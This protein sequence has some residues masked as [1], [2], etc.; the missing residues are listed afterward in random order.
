MSHIQ[1]PERLTL[2][3]ATTI[4]IG[5]MIG[6]G[7]FL[8]VSSMTKVLPSPA[9]LLAAWLL[10]GILT[11]CGSLTLAEMAARFPHT[12]G[13]YVYMKE[14]Y[15]KLAGY[16]FGWSLL[17]VM[18]TGS[19]AAMAAGAAQ[20]LVKDPSQ[21]MFLGYA[22]I[23][24]LTIVHCVSVRVGIGVLQNLF[25]V[26]KGIGIMSV[27][28][29]GLMC[30]TA[31]ASNL[32]TVGTIPTGFALL[33]ALG[34]VMMKSLWAYDG[35]IN[36]TFIAGELKDARRQL[37]KALI[38]GSLL[39]MVLYCLANF[40][41]HY[42]LAPG[43]LI[44]SD[45]PAALI[46]QTAAGQGAFTAVVFLVAFSMF[47]TLNGSIMSAPRVYFAMAADGLF[48]KQMS[49][50]HP[51]FE[52]PYVSL[53][54]QAAWSSLL[55]T[56]WGSFDQITDNVMFIYWIFYALAA[57]AIFKYPTEG[58]SYVTPAR[59]L[60]AGLF[61]VA[62]SFLILNSLYTNW[63][64]ALQGLALIAVGLFIYPFVKRED[65]GSKVNP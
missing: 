41:Y 37:P 31:S 52:T 24:S 38:G 42:A 51:R 55:L 15:G 45:K 65:L 56:W 19:I 7:V 43:Q 22:M 59:P 53:L 32:G 16:L 36:A 9:W 25:T 26:A 34:A 21:R 30:P 23:W 3:D 13:L 40:S 49:E 10:T 61:I 48:F 47:G 11:L 62:A 18:E 1:L 2:V 8:K 54:V 28:V 33:S 57:A 46:A 12:G 64:G 6:S 44:E 5:S 27:I 17:T 35:W 50:V 58:A 29:F 39:V 20:M 14:G 63:E 60:T 4:V